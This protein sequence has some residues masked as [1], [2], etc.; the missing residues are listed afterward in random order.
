MTKPTHRWL[1]TQIDDD[2]NELITEVVNSS[3]LV[4]NRSALARHGIQ[5]ALRDLV[6]RDIVT[7]PVVQDRI[8]DYL[9]SPSITIV[10][11]SPATLK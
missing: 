3:S 2:L 6:E 11:E 4:P 10:A 5:L 7:D 9:E 8:K 1:S